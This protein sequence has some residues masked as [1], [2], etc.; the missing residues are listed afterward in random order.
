MVELPALK[1]RQFLSKVDL[2]AFVIPSS[3]SPTN[4][5]ANTL[6]SNFPFTFSDF[7]FTFKI[8]NLSSYFS[9]FRKLISS[10]V[11]QLLLKSQSKYS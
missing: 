10:F 1:A 3:T 7:P 2:V 11:R 4:T 5:I 6:N 8:D 9:K